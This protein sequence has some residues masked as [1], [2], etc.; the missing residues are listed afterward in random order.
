M[1]RAIILIFLIIS[2]L[3]ICITG[4]SQS[5]TQQDLDIAYGQGW[6]DGFQAATEAYEPTPITTPTKPDATPES[7]PATKKSITLRGTS[8][9]TTRPFRVTTEE[10]NI[11]WSYQTDDPEWAVFSLFIYPRGETVGYVEAIMST[12]SMS[13]STYSY[14]GPGEYYIVVGAANIKSWVIN[15]HEE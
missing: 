6:L 5:Y 2:L 1:K 10:W 13:G 9:E 14:A 3:S 7:T 11:E 4:C 8:D 12:G 15:I